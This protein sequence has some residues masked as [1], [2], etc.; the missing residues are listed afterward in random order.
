[1]LAEQ[2]VLTS[3]QAVKNARISLFRE[4]T[5]NAKKILYGG[6]KQKSTP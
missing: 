6:R 2:I 3:N 1:M 5:E 4:M